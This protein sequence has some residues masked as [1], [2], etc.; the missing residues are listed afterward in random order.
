MQ[1]LE[2]DVEKI[3]AAVAE[4]NMGHDGARELE[5]HIADV[6]LATWSRGYDYGKRDYGRN[7]DNSV[8]P[9]SGV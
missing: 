3:T 7:D 9:H 1:G 8:L 4:Y 6:L 2:A 5:V